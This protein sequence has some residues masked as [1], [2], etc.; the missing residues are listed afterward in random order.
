MP[1]QLFR[2]MQ[3]PC[4]D[5]EWLYVPN[6]EYADSP[7]GKLFLQLIIPYQ[8]GLTKR[9]PLILFI[10]GAAWH[11]PEVY[12]SIP[13]YAKLAERGFVT[14]VLQHRGSETAHFPAPIQDTKAAIR[15]LVTKAEAFH[16]D[17]NR[18]YLMGNS[19]GGHIALMTALTEA[20]G[21]YDSDLYP[22]V[23]FQIKGV[24]AESAP[25]DLIRCAEEPLPEFMRGQPRP[26]ELFLGVQGI[27]EHPE[28]AQKASCG[29]YITESVG[30]P[31]I[32]LIHGVHDDQVSV[33]Q[34]RALSALLR[35]HNKAV[36]YLELENAG[37]GGNAFW[38]PEVLGVVE[39][40]LHSFPGEEPG[41]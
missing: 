17:V 37:H 40:F 27:P 11:S 23:P 3:I 18:I 15:F 19:S 4:D 36:W 26:T 14:A 13:A 8:P 41:T 7:S 33:E 10:P 35:Q 22:G 12:N 29:Q 20:H 31:P 6:V 1:K 30:I 16:I 21:L 32:L 9:Y 28:L 39:A 5:L 34:S 38:S 25:S 24:I 2:T